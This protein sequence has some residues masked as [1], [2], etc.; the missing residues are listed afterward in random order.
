M[1]IQNHFAAFCLPF[2]LPQNS[3][4][5]RHRNL[6]MPRFRKIL[7]KQNCLTKFQQN[8]F[9][10]VLKNKLRKN[11]LILFGN[12]VMVRDGNY[13]V[14]YKLFKNNNAKRI[15]KIMSANS[16]KIKFGAERCPVKIKI[17]SAT[18]ESFV[19]IR[20]ANTLPRL[21]GSKFFANQYGPLQASLSGSLASRF[22]I[23]KEKW[24]SDE[25]LKKIHCLF[26]GESPLSSLELFKKMNELLL[27]SFSKWY[28]FSTQEELDRS[29]QIRVIINLLSLSLKKLKAS[30]EDLSL[31]VNLQLK[32]LR[33]LESKLPKSVYAK[34]RN[35]R[36]SK[37]L[38]GG[39]FAALSA[40]SWVVHL[41]NLGVHQFMNPS[42]PFG[43]PLAVQLPTQ[44]FKHIYLPILM[45]HIKPFFSNILGIFNPI[46]DGFTRVLKGSKALSSLSYVLSGV[47]SLGGIA[48]TKSFLSLYSSGISTFSM[49]LLSKAALAAKGMVRFLA[50][51]AL[52]G[53]VA[54][55]V[56]AF[57]SLLKLGQ[58]VW[59]SRSANQNQ[60]EKLAHQSKLSKR[61][62][63]FVNNALMAVGF[64]VALVSGP[65]GWSL[66]GA[67]A[68][69]MIGLKIF[70]IVKAYKI[71]KAAEKSL[72]DVVEVS[73]KA[74]NIKPVDTLDLAVSRS[75]SVQALTPTSNSPQ[76]PCSERSSRGAFT[77]S[78]FIDGDDHPH[79]HSS[80]SLD[81]VGPFG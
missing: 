56:S 2:L 59:K 13:T 23:S 20:H 18:V 81:P 4:S 8:E 80:S 36:I 61:S 37:I 57:V 28:Q 22:Q 72:A 74:V 40:F 19:I 31:E 42:N 32:R 73:V 50:F 1:P 70:Q 51:G 24:E 78:S 49:P 75:A 5:L 46:F 25:S 16:T 44:G 48:Y 47:F 63:S 66:L 6:A 62:F 41:R 10:W 43:P 58:S 3:S 71:K 21:L 34:K 17:D 68:L 52:L 77:F 45:N 60:A 65:V 11:V 35:A 79:Q 64:G 54:S 26:P 69:G 39:W 38:N 7:R 55:S 9:A 33:A 30:R 53:I 14:F 76:A 29:A 12:L 15:I 27:K 67:G